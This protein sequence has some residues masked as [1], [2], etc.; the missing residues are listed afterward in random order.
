VKAKRTILS[1]FMTLAMVASLCAV[2]A[3]P[4]SADGDLEWAVWD[5]NDGLSTMSEP[6]GEL[7]TVKVQG[8]ESLASMVVRL[9]YDGTT[10]D[11]TPTTACTS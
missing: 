11:T 3:A 5:E 10:V 7:I 2:A 8:K 1:V 9:E 4:A 6:V